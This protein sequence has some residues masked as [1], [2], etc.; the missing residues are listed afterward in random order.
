MAGSYEGV[1]KERTIIPPASV[2]V[3]LVAILTQA[4]TTGAFDGRKNFLN[5]IL[6]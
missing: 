2:P 3:F 6:F 4:K 5:K 1:Y